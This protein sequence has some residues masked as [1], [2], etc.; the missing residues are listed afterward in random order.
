M[1]NERHGER[2]T[3]ACVCAQ[4]GAALPDNPIVFVHENG[5]RVCEDAAGC[6]ERQGG[7]HNPDGGECYPVRLQLPDHRGESRI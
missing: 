4:C 2:E 6:Y 3:R 5:R 1:T 7:D